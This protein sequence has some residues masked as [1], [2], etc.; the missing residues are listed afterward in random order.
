MVKGPIVWDLIY[1]FNQRWVYSIWKDIR[2]VKKIVKPSSVGSYLFSTS[3]SAVLSFT[4]EGD[5][6][7]TA[8]RT[9]K[10]IL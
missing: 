6:E 9:W 10:Q 7:I 5:T 8:L 3:P 4:G 2:Q 1:H